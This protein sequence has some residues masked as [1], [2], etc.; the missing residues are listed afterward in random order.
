MAR[1]GAASGHGNSP[2]VRVSS[3]RPDI[4]PATCTAYSISR[5][6]ICA[7][8][9]TA[10][11]SLPVIPTSSATVS[12]PCD[13]TQGNPST[14][15]RSTHLHRS[16]RYKISHRHRSQRTC[17]SQRSPHHPHIR[18]ISPSRPRMES[19][20]RA[21]RARVPSLVTTRKSKSTLTSFP[22]GALPQNTPTDSFARGLSPTFVISSI[23]YLFTAASADALAAIPATRLTSGQPT[24]LRQPPRLLQHNECI[25]DCA[26]V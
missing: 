22:R 20:H 2:G 15:S 7:E 13:P 25:S 21:T 17:P 26:A 6:V 14:N 4:W 23:A 11:A 1:G 19:D 8:L 12:Q 9:E 24:A 16:S 10:A 3:R 5:T 18:H